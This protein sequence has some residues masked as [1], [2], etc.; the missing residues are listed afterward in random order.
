MLPIAEWGWSP[1]GRRAYDPNQPRAGRMLRGR[2]V[3]IPVTSTATIA[4]ITM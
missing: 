2:Q 3:R 4:A 1:P